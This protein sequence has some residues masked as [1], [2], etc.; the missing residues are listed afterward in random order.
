M[1]ILHQNSLFWQFNMTTKMKKLIWIL[2][3]SFALPLLAWQ[4]LASNKALVDLEC[5]EEKGKTYYRGVWMKGT[6]GQT[7]KSYA[8]VEEFEADVLVMTASGKALRDIAIKE[9]K[10]GP[11]VVAVYDKAAE[12]SELKRIGSWD[13]FEADWKEKQK[14]GMQIIDFDF[15][16]YLGEDV[17]YAIYR[18]QDKKS[19]YF[20]TANW[21][22]MSEHIAAKGAKKYELKDVDRAMINGSWHYVAFF[23]EGEKALEYKAFKVTSNEALER[24]ATANAEKGIILME[25]DGFIQG[26]AITH[27]TVYVKQPQPNGFFTSEDWVT[28]E[29]KFA[30]WN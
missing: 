22:E 9:T 30:E 13:D 27:L 26:N 3:L 29:T 7:L 17:Y 8:N 10:E 21:T 15:Y 5:F 11:Q 28:F 23:N 6:G 18:K 19:E 24:Q 25:A 4:S 1:G 12:T 20:I 2:G 16:S 14:S